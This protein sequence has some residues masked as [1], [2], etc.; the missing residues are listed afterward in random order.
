MPAPGVT[1]V[2]G[3]VRQRYGS[4]VS[5]PRPH[6]LPGPGPAL[7]TRMITSLCAAG[8]RHYAE[9]APVCAC[10]DLQQRNPGHDLQL[11]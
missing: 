1:A 2:K 4:K 5:S 10:R 6:P 8:L 3:L 11:P 9:D 7:Q